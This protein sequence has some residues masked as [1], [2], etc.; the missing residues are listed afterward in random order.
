MYDN[1]SSQVIIVLLLMFIAVNLF[2]LDLKV[3]YS[4]PVVKVSDM[5][6]ATTPI[7]PPPDVC[8]ETCLSFTRE[9]IEKASF[10]SSPTQI[11]LP[12]AQKV[13]QTKE[14]YIPMGTGSTSESSWVDLNTTDTVIDTSLYGTIKEVYFTA[15]L[16]N[17]TQNGQAEVQLYNVTEKHPVWNT[18]LTVGNAS[19]KTVSSGNIV[20]GTGSNTYRVQLKST[21]Q[22]LVYLE[23]AKIRIIAVD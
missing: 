20:L 11:P 6:I 15:S 17:P 19:S 22:Y 8:P 9:E 16:R 12:A 14:Y 21:L 13:T 7:L 4:P 1:T 18:H 5:Q 23:G 10:R 3:F 2:I